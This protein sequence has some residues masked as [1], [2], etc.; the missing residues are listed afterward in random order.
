LYSWVNI[1]LSFLW[2]LPK[3]SVVRR[4]LVSTNAVYG[5]EISK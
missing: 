1:A 5:W 3:G 2:S 4:K